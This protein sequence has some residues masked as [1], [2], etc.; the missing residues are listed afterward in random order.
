MLALQQI[1][2]A[3][4][5]LFA[6]VAGSAINVLSAPYYEG[7]IRITVRDTARNKDVPITIIYPAD[8][9]SGDNRPLVGTGINVIPTFGVVVVG[10]GYQMP[11]SSCLLYAE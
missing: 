6:G 7:R 10:H 4:A 3:L 9:S 5:L 1:I 2:L 11:V 8:S